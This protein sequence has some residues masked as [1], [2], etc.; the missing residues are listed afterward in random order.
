MIPGKETRTMKTIRFLL[1]LSGV[2]VSAIT[3]AAQSFTYTVENSK[4]TITGFSAEPSGAVVVP[5]TL[6]GY[7]VT[8]VGRAAFKD[9]TGI[10]AISFTSGA[11]ITKLGA[12]AFHGCT[13]LTS[14]SLPSGATTLPAGLLKGCSSLTSVTIPGTVTAI[15]PMAFAGCGNLASLAL[16]SALTSLGESVFTDCRSLTALTIPSGVTTIPAQLCS[17]CSSLSSISFAGNVASIGANAFHAC[18]ALTTFNLPNS[19][20]TVGT[21]AFSG[22][23]ALAGLGFGTGL[24]S[25]AD[26]AFHGCDSLATFS[27][28]S[29]NPVFS[30]SNGVL[31]TA[32]QTTLLRCPPAM[33]GDYTIPSGV[34][35]LGE[36]AF[37]NCGNLTS[38]QLPAALANI[39]NDAFYYASSL[40]SP[41]LTSSVTAI[42]AWAYAGLK[43]LGSLTIPNTVS[44]LG[45]D[46]FHSASSL[47]W[48]I[49]TGN[50]PS[51]MGDEVFDAA[52][53]GFT[54]F[55]H[56]T[57]TGFTS[58]EW[59]GYTAVELGINSAIVEWLTDNGFTPGSSLL[60]DSNKD[61]VSLLAAYALGL[62]PNLDL[63]G[64]MPVPTLSNGTLSLTFHGDSTGIVYGAETSTDLQTWSGTGVT[65]T[66]PDGNGRRTASISVGAEARF[67]RLVLATE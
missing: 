2:L 7:A 42:G 36:G 20:T 10:T 59:M 67:L 33:T 12:M 47:E 13:G 1:T 24:T 3:A 63:S 8:E 4:T 26:L 14:I 46:A 31:F 16:P 58:P 43:K 52:A 56:S 61:G 17:G 51:T 18:S 28:A 44:N 15:G 39:A 50:A 11:S 32:A 34:N 35:A 38:I 55:Y 22:C 64:S 19:V 45:S 60:A 57:S 53:E 65:M 9:R 48:V 29:G 21:G 41:P 54:I 62:D 5:S 23:S 6:G 27:V 30:S 40:T 66:S 37:A 49:F 25:M